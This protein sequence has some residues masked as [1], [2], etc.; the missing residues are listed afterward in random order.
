MKL[1]LLDNDH[2]EAASDLDTMWHDADREVVEEKIISEL[3]PLLKGYVELDDLQTLVD[4]K[5][6]DRKVANKLLTLI[7]D[8]LEFK[9]SDSVYYSPLFALPPPFFKQA[10]SFKTFEFAQQTMRELM[11]LDSR[12]TGFLPVALFRSALEHELKIKPKIV[13]DFIET[14]KQPAKSLDVNCTASQF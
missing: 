4:E 12:G 10:S 9:N 11:S 6:T 8:N 3:D 1:Y 7:N 5:I 14:G 2:A 13:E